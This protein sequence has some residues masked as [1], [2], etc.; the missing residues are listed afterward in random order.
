MTGRPPRILIDA[1]AA[2]GPGKTGV[3]TYASRLVELLPRTDPTATYV[4]WYLHVRGALG[5]SPQRRLFDHVEGSNVEQVRLPIPTRVFERLATE[6]RVPRVEWT[7]RFDVLFAPNFVPPPTR[8]RN[9]VLTVHDLA[10]KRFPGTAPSSTRHWLGR[11]DRAVERASRIVTVSEHSRL[12]L[13]ELYRVDPDRVAVVPLAVDAAAYRPAPE[14]AVSSVRRR[15][16]ID[17]PY[18]LALTAIEPRKNL[19]ALVRAFAELPDDVRPTLVIAGPEARWNPEGGRL[20]RTALEA[21]PRRVRERIVLTGYVELPEKLALL[22]GAEAL[23]YPSLYEGFGLPV[24]EAMAC[25]TPVLTSNVSALPETAGDAAVL[26]DPADVGAIG[27]GIA[28]LLTDGALRERLRRLG[29]E[30]IRAF[31]W[32]RTARGTVEVLHAALG[33]ARR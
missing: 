29:A 12:D 24:L 13:I 10:F 5:L 16:A 17:G 31:D 6:V 23:A 9:V 28:R 8:S 3:G 30:R 15:Y 2:V 14:A 18:L 7:T 25:G 26:V 21:V 11:L 22:T 20:L 27:D 32:E 19:P 4:L 1:R 33:E